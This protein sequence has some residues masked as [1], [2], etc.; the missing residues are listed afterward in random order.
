MVEQV[1]AELSS[2]RRA[3]SQANEYVSQL[4]SGLLPSA[5]KTSEASKELSAT[6]KAS[7][8]NDDRIRSESKEAAATASETADLSK[9]ILSELKDFSKNF[10]SL[11]RGND[12]S[13]SG[14]ILG[15]GVGGASLAFASIGGDIFNETDVN[16]NTNV[17]ANYNNPETG[18]EP[19]EINGINFAPEAISSP[20][21]EGAHNETKVYASRQNIDTTANMF[22]Q[23]QGQFGGSL[24]VNDFIPRAT[25]SRTPP[26]SGGGS[27]HWYGKAMDISTS[28][29][30]DKDK[31]RL[32][33]AALT[34]GFKGFGFGNNILHVDWGGSRAWGYRNGQATSNLQG[35][36]YGGMPVEQLASWVSGGQKPEEVIEALESSPLSKPT[37]EPPPSAA[38]DEMALDTPQV[39][40]T[41]D[42]SQVARN[43]TE[44]NDLKTA[45]IS[46]AS[47]SNLETPVTPEA[48]LDMARAEI[49]TVNF[50]PEKTASTP[51]VDLSPPAT[52]YRTA[53]LSGANTSR[54]VVTPAVNYSAPKETTVASLGL[55]ATRNP[56]PLDI[57]F[58]TN[59]IAEAN[60]KN[61]KNNETWMA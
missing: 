1:V 37:S 38:E 56:K 45:E 25:T 39:Q 40:G 44:T 58:D 57:K 54:P 19:V 33:E 12:G 49:E 34:S 16:Q 55:P 48:S 23:M 6:A 22:S 7:T 24:I 47:F 18:F 20:N 31:L 29:M 60:R 28:G 2:F 53:G 35:L 51:A 27:M 26:S 52:N 14:D 42:V 4:F 5:S 13:L 9:Q 17:N 30:N 43:N 3:A 15:F 10:T 32:V 46:Q 36:E 8:R 50:E 59:W 21:S 41:N 11:I 61:Q